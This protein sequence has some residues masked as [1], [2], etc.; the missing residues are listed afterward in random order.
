MHDG[1][2]PKVLYLFA[3]GGAIPLEAAQP[4]CESH[5]V[6]YHLV[7]HMIKLCTLVYPLTY[8]PSL[9]NDFQRWSHWSSIDVP[10]SKEVS[11]QAEL[12]GNRDTTSESRADPLPT[13]SH[14]RSNVGE[15]WGQIRPSITEKT[16]KTS[17]ETT[18]NQPQPNQ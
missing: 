1:R 10:R 9:A 2:T 15:S 3:G 14:V 16:G 13:S 18:L 7:A 6:D 5:A 12:F 11:H 17:V 4:G 8:R